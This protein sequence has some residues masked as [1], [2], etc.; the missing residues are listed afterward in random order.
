MPEGAEHHGEGRGNLLRGIWRGFEIV[1]GTAG[2]R[3]F[4]ESA[5]KVS[6]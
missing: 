4:L 3:H 5:E 1:G 6:M 2:C